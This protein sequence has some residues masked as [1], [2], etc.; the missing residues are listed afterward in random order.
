MSFAGA[1]GETERQMTNTLH[2]ELPQG[3]LHTSFNA[4]DQELASRGEDLRA[5]ENQFFEL[6]IANAIWGQQGYEF[7][8]DFLDALAENYGAGL[9]PLDFASAP[10]EWRAIINDWVSSKRPRTR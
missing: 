6:N 2:Y 1:R 8:P 4:L 9:R 5:E 10:E 3:R 7:L